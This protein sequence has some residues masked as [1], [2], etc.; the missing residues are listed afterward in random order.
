MKRT[1]FVIFFLMS[2]A[3][4]LA[5]DGKRSLD[6]G[7]TFEKDQRWDQ[8][9][10]VYENVVGSNLD[11]AITMQ[12]KVRLGRIYLEEKNDITKARP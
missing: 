10:S 11:Q 2:C 1:A 12:A 9:I 7:D 3:G 4:I 5:Q 6:T 8:A